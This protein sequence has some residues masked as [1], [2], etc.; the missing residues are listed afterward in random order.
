[1]KSQF[2]I[3]YRV[4]GFIWLGNGIR[5]YASNRDN[6]EENDGVE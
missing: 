3:E 5:L 2:K 4:K 1:M 6:R